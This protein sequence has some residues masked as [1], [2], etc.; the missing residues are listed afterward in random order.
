MQ[1]GLLKILEDGKFVVRWN[2]KNYE[3]DTSRLL[4]VGMGSFSRIILNNK[5]IGFE[6]NE[7]K[8][9]YKDLTRN[10]FIENGMI[11]EFIGR[12]PTIVQMNELD[13]YS[14]LKILDTSK[15]NAFALNKS[16]LERQG[17]KLTLEEGVK[18]AIAKKAVKDNFGARSLD[19]I[20]DRALSIA[21]FEIAK[22]P[23]LYEEPIITEDTIKDNNSYKLVRKISNK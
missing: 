12:F 6:K 8:R 9:Q 13:Y 11:P 10:D 20:I 18:A 5:V 19:E 2:N 23:E 21:S 22:N 3:F 14:F 4:V 15:N 16:F 7:Q 17:I 1:E